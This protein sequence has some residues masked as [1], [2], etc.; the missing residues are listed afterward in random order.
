MTVPSLKGLVHFSQL[1]QGLTTP[2]RAKAARVGVVKP[3]ASIV[4]PLRGWFLSAFLHY[5]KP[6]RRRDTVSESP[7]YPNSLDKGAKACSAQTASI[8]TVS[9]FEQAQLHFQSSLCLCV[10]VVQHQFTASRQFG[11]GFRDEFLKS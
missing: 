8:S 10:S 2:T 11:K 9:P 1:T 4:S 7:H 6:I 5:G 3:W